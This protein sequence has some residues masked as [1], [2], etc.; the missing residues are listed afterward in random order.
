MH[1]LAWLEKQGKIF[2]GTAGLTL[3]AAIGIL[4]FLTGQELAISLFYL[5]PIFFVTWFLG[6]GQGIVVALAGALVLLAAGIYSGH[7]YQNKM[8]TVLN[9]FIRFS[10][11]LV[12][13]SLLSALKNALEREKASAS[14]DYLTG[15][16]NSRR[17]FE[18]LKMECGRL[19]RYGRPFTLAY[20]DLDN[21]KEVNDQFGHPEGD[22][23]LR[24]IVRY[25]RGHLR[26]IDV[27]ARLGGDELAFL[28]PE[29]DQE[30]ARAVLVKLQG[31]LLAEMKRNHW[32]VTFS[33]GV[34]T[35]NKDVPKTAT[36]LVQ[37]ADALM[38]SVKHNGKNGIAYLTYAG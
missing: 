28:L 25:A 37:V 8:M 13:L 27:I 34:V 3:L 16:A 26:E 12:A 2:K 31:G 5:F 24:T 10:L 29:L 38:Y 9:V 1:I 35:C 11:F 23:A 4:D 15:A 33:I 7:I 36:Q 19:Q 21:F 32:P 17:F 20:I 18:L 22:E 30:A 14:T 6:R